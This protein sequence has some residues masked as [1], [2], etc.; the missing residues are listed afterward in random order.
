MISEGVLQFLRMKDSN[1]SKLLQFLRMKG[2]NLS[3]FSED[4]QIFPDLS[5]FQN[6]EGSKL[7]EFRTFMMKM[8]T[9]IKS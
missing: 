2:S 1:L 7:Y 8:H 3:K 9:F 4:F 6:E 5:E